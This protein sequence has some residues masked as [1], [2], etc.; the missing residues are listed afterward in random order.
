MYYRKLKTSSYKNSANF[1][2]KMDT[3]SKRNTLPFHKYKILFPRST[4]SYCHEHEPKVGTLSSKL[5]II[6]QAGC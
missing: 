5:T 4:K 2:N 6:K 1:L 3:C